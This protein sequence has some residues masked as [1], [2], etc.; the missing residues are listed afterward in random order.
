[1]SLHHCSFER[2]KILLK[3]VIMLNNLVLCLSLTGKDEFNSC[4]VKSFKRAVSTL[5]TVVGIKCCA[6]TM[7]KMGGPFLALKT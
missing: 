5:L 6:V 3:Q 2:Y 7:L 4:S 1:M